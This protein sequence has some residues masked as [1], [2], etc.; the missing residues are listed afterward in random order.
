[1]ETQKEIEQG[2]EKKVKGKENE[3]EKKKKKKERTYLAMTGIYQFNSLPCQ[4]Y[5]AFVTR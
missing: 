5:S 3:G 4:V 1:M 2:S